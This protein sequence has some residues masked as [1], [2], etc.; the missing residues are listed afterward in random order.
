MRVGHWGSDHITG[1]AL[2]ISTT[3]DHMV[4]ITGLEGGQHPYALYDAQGRTVAQGVV[5][6]TAGQARIPLPDVVPALYVLRIADHAAQVLHVPN[7]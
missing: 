2:T 1:T 5:R 3:T 4:L 6:A 7:R